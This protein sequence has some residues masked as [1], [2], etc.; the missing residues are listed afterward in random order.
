MAL[1]GRRQPHG[2]TILRGL[3]TPGAPVGRVVVPQGQLAAHAS[4]LLSRRPRGRITIVRGLGQPSFNRIVTPAGQQTSLAAALAP[5]RPLGKVQI[6]HAGGP[7]STSR[8]IVPQGQF[9]AQAAALASRSPRGHI[10]AIKGGGQPSVARIVIRGTGVARDAANAAHRPL[11]Q[12]IIRK[13]YTFAPPVSTTPIGVV[14]TP[15]GVAASQAAS[16]STRRPR[17]KI[18]VIQSGGPPSVARALV[19]GERTARD[20]AN[21]AHRPLFQPI[22][23]TLIRFAT[24]AATAPVGKVVTPSGGAASQ[25]AALVRR[26]NGKIQVIRAGGRAVTTA[27]L[28]I[29]QGQLAAQAAAYAPRRPAGKVTI[30]KRGA[31]AAVSQSVLTGGLASR[32]ACNKAYR[33]LFQPIIRTVGKAAPVAHLV[34]P[35]GQSNSLAAAYAPRRPAGRI[36]VGKRGANTPISRTMLTG[37][38][39]SRDAANRAH[40][41]TFQPVQRR[42]IQYTPLVVGPPIGRTISPTGTRAS[43]DAAN[44][45]HRPLFHPVIQRV[46]QYAPPLALPPSIFLTGNIQ[47]NLGTSGNAQRNVVLGT[48]LPLPIPPP[49]PGPPIGSTV[50]AKGYKASRDAANWAHRPLFQPVIRSN[51]ISRT[52]VV[53]QTFPG[54]ASNGWGEVLSLSVVGNHLL[55]GNLYDYNAAYTG[56]N[57]TFAGTYFDKIVSVFNLATGSLDTSVGTYGQLQWNLANSD[58]VASFATQSDGKILAAGITAD[59]IGSQMYVNIVRYNSNFTLDPTFGTF[60]IAKLS[61]LSGDTQCIAISLQ[62]TGKIVGVCNFVA[63]INNDFVRFF[64]IHEN[65]A[66]DST[67][68]P[69]ANGLVNF[70]P[71]ARDTLGT[72]YYGQLVVDSGDRL[73]FAGI[74]DVS[75]AGHYEGAAFRILSDGLA[76]D[77]QT[78]VDLGSAG[79]FNSISFTSTGKAI[80]CGNGTLDAAHQQGAAALLTSAG[81]LDISFNATGLL[82]SSFGDLASAYLMQPIQTA[83]GSFR[84]IGAASSGNNFLANTVSKTTHMMVVGRLAD[85]SQDNTF[86]TSGT[87]VYP[88]NDMSWGFCTVQLTDGTIVVGGHSDQSTTGVAQATLW[89]LTPTGTLDLNRGDALNPPSTPTAPTVV[90]GASSSVTST[91]ATIAGTVNPNSTL[92]T[93]HFEYGPTLT[94]GSRTNEQTVGSQSSAQSISAN[95]TGLIP[96]HT[97]HYR[98][99]S[100]N[101]SIG[102]GAD[103]TLTTSSGTYT[104]LSD[105][106]TDTNSTPVVTHTGRAQTDYTGTAYF[107]NDPGVGSAA[108]IQGNKLQRTANHLCRV[109]R[110]VNGTTQSLVVNVTYRSGGG[111]GGFSGLGAMLRA[112][113]TATSIVS[114][115]L[116]AVIEDA[117]FRVYAL[118]SASITNIGSIPFIPVSGQSYTIRCAVSGNNVTAASVDGVSG[119]ISGAIDAALASNTY[120]GVC[121]LQG[122]S[123]FNDTVNSLQ[124]D[125]TV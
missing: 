7:A 83:S 98:L 64:R 40:R 92:A 70:Q 11:F 120:A 104:V 77:W 67:F 102:L 118:V 79:T 95:I 87:Y 49:P 97:Y 21:Q 23:R 41:P 101:G 36:T 82:K 59:S 35:Q 112:T 3:Q 47:R 28:V 25:A 105:N 26:P 8:Q 121:F 113:S 37:G 125:L 108:E 88:T 65:G 100:S 122:L 50:T 4:S 73:Y 24:A 63:G 90:T 109:H 58:G 52:G 15:V 42:L 80:V 106:F 9:S 114:D 115:G 76:I 51:P 55:A 38:S 46:I 61:I 85:G 30:G 31:P 20:A 16:L 93:C 123:S 14:V 10:A 71:S 22:V 1:F 78:N 17:G 96:G 116:F 19:R 54:G 74:Y 18:Q 62:S 53:F 34:I 110:N 111:S 29:P 43:R 84:F 81:A 99:V 39:A 27:R 103:A 107:V 91:T 69:N 6:I 57:D 72:G 86:G 124:V 2:P 13:L 44:W 5:R 75:G 117:G 32:A 12:P 60:G 66:L 89:F 33:P 48:A 68:G 94:Y 119:T 45:A 56:G